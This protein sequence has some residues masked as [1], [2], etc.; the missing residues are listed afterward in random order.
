MLIIHETD[1]HGCGTV[2][3]NGTEVRYSYDDE[4]GDIR[5]AVEFLIEIGYVNPED[6][7]IFDDHKSIYEQ[8]DDFFRERG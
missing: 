7:L 6:V 8:L 2:Y 4:I 3:Y 5:R 1:C